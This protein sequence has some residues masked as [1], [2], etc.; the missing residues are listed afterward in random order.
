MATYRRRNGK[1]NAQVRRSG[2]N[3]IS[4]TFTLKTDAI[5]WAIEIE[6][7]LET[8]TYTDY[9][10]ATTTRLSEL[11]TRYNE[12][13]VPTLKGK[14]QDSSRIKNIINN[15]LGN[16]LIADLTSLL[17]AK[18]RDNRLKQLGPQSVKHELSMV[19]R[20]LKIATTEWGYHLPNG[21]PTVKHPT[22]PKG[23]TRRLTKEEESALR[24]AGDPYLCHTIS[25]L[26]ATA[27]RIGELAKL[28]KD[29][30][31]FNK[32]LAILRDTKNGDSRTIPLSKVAIAAL[33]ELIRESTTDRVLKFTSSCISHRFN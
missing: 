21:I 19:N 12:E 25:L 10:L 17:L 11:L 31:D 27:M 23:R 22:L 18:Y 13:V 7:K 4:K 1:W 9:K 15:D 30:V 32:S 14:H 2:K 20:V 33:E 3:D 28:K 6:V 16:Q 24:K 29:D 26:Q 8:E 5:K